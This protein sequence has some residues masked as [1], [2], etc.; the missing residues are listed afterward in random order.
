[1]NESFPCSGPN[2]MGLPP[3]R[4]SSE[5]PGPSVLPCANEGQEAVQALQALSDQGELQHR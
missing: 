4:K 3:K 1:M 5:S 2:S